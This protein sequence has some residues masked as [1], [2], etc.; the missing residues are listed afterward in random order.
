[1]LSFFKVNRGVEVKPYIFLISVHASVPS[2][3]EKDP[4]VVIGWVGL[5]IVLA[6]WQK[7]N[8]CLGWV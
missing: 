7:V 1:M 8:T 3:S 6:W 5:K 4:S 2:S